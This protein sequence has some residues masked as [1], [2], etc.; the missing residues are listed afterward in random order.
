[1][2]KNR[3]QG[4]DKKPARETNQSVLKQAMIR[5]LPRRLG[6]SGQML[7]PAAPALLEHYVQNLHQVFAQFGRTFSREE[8]EHLRGIL[9]RKLEEAFAASPY[10]RVVVHYETD[11]PP[12]TSLTYKVNVAVSTIADEYEGWV[13]T[14]TPP[15]FGAHP[16]A[17][18]MAVAASLGEPKDVPVLDIGAGTGRNTLPLARGGFPTDAVELTP[19]LAAILRGEVE[20][21][22][23]KVRV[24]EGDALAGGMDLPE[25]HYKLVFLAEVIASHIRTTD[26]VRAL[27]EGAADSLAPGGLLLF[28]AFLPMD[29]YKPDPVARELSQVFWCNLFT[30]G[31]ITT[32]MQGLPFDIVSDE[33]THDYELE[34]QP[35]EGWPPTGWFVDWS[36][37]NDLYDVPSGRAPMELRWLTYR[38]V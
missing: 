32:A 16:D 18:V 21:E 27:F 11:P 24:F 31:E 34:H 4:K 2:G 28:N 38:K 37:G 30:R 15:Y 1:M 35:K 3:P 5:R 7:L 19:S 26:Q 8:T 14:R 20:K 10:A 25:N 36:R 9:K 29:G 23:L 12:K 13:K 22:G 33:S 17:K 6:A